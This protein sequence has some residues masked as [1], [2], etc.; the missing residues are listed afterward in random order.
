MLGPDLLEG[1][2]GMLSNDGGISSAAF[3]G[4]MDVL[5]FGDLD[6]HDFYLFLGFASAVPP[7]ARQGMFTR[8]MNNEDILRDLTVPVLIQQGEEDRLVL[9]AAADNIARLVPGATKA[10]YPNC[11]HA[12]FFEVTDRFNQDL[13]AFVRQCQA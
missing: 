4:F 5:T 1:A 11:G 3:Q 7:S 9:K 12:P 2:E 8:E 10:Y 13:G 6:P